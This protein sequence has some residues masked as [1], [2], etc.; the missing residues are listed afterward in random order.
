MQ[1]NPTLD[2]E[3]RPG[4][5]ERY[6]PLVRRVAIKTIRS[7][8]AS[9]TL[10]DLLSAGWVGL[11]EALRRRT[12]A[13]SEQDFEAY[14]LHR[15]QGAILDY[16]RSLDPL[17]RRLRGASKRITEVTTSLTQKL[18][19]SP[20]EE[21]IA[22]ELGLTL[23]AYRQVL[24]DVAEAGLVRLELDERVHMAADQVSPE[25]AASQR[26]L[27]DLVADAIGSLPERLQLVLALHHQE[28]CSFR[29]MAEILDVTESRACQL[30]A[31]AVHRIR[32]RLQLSRS[33]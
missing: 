14:A 8:P 31:E 30:H 23:D 32:S 1:A 4:V 22:G 21:E 25:A 16:L 2:R 6:S 5:F 19:R 12:L 11:S 18:G 17:S 15:V 29:E 28:Q 20:E 26:E 13:M 9:V 10:D 3:P 27:L 24:T 33:L 7:L